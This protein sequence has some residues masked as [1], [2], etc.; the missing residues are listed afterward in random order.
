MVA[1]GVETEAQ[2]L[3]LLKTGCTQYQGVLYSPAVDAVSFEALLDRAGWPQRRL[4][5][6]TRSR[7]RRPER[8]APIRRLFLMVLR[9]TILG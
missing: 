9:R 5:R 8:G 4:R 3:F 6:S 1:E 7:R 2:R